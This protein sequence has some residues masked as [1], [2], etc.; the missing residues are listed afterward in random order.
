VT[1]QYKPFWTNFVR[2]LDAEPRD[3]PSIKGISG[4]DH[5]TLGFGVDDKRQRVVIISADHDARSAAMMQADVQ[6]TFPGVS[7]VVARPALINLSGMASALIRELG[8]KTVS[9][10]DLA[11]AIEDKDDLVSVRKDVES[12]ESF[13]IQERW[14]DSRRVTDVDGTEPQALR[15]QQ[16]SI[17]QRSDGR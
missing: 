14:P 6:A 9:I 10:V 3:V 15:P 7:I 1:S 8:T 5:P 17:S 4:L 2:A 11:K 13:V 12:D 16:A